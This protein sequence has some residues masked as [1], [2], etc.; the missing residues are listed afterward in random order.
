MQ[1]EVAQAKAEG[2]EIISVDEA[3]FSSKGQKRGHWA[4]LNRPMQW[5]KSYFGGG[6]VSVCMGTSVERGVVH[7]KLL[8]GKAYDSALFLTFI[9]E[10][11][12]RHCERRSIAILLDNLRLH[13]D[14]AVS[15]Y[16]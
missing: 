2:R 1:R 7:Y 12:N 6:Y 13:E 9:K 4:P 5:N 11:R 3:I 16:C 15:D 14:Q 10:L 8:A